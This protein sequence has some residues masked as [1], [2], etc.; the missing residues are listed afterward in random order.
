MITSVHRP[1]TG[2]E[3][4]RTIADRGRPVPATAAQAMHRLQRLL[5]GAGLDRMLLG[6]ERGVSVLSVPSD[7][8]V[9][10][11]NGRITWRHGTD[12]HVTVEIHPATDPEGA[13][14]H[15]LALLRG[16]RHS[17]EQEE[18]PTEGGP[19]PSAAE[20]SV[21]GRDTGPLKGGTTVPVGAAADRSRRPVTSR[22]IGPLPHP[23]RQHT[24]RGSTSR[25]GSQRHAVRPAR[26]R[27]PRPVTAARPPR[28]A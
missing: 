7:L 20:V 17:D 10:C 2:S 24:D 14:H 25:Q 21:Q 18:S 5:T 9:W 6:H 27:R 3:P 19:A 15:L 26:P 22:L 12:R 13:A 23:R 4:Q 8:T 28:A 1:R 16:T 11:V